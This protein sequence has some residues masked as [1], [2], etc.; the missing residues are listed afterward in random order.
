MK[1][2]ILAMLCLEPVVCR[3]KYCNVIQPVEEELYVILYDV[4]KL[5]VRVSLY[6]PLSVVLATFPTQV[7]T[8]SSLT[9]ELFTVHLVATLAS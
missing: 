1:F 8:N 2:L 3:G 9:F 4:V 6:F 5:D 7:S